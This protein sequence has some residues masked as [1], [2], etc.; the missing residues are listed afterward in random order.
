MKTNWNQLPVFVIAIGVAILMATYSGPHSELVFVIGFAVIFGAI[1]F[2]GIRNSL[3]K[4]RL[5]KQGVPGTARLVSSETTGTYSGHSPEMRLLL[6]V[7]GEAGQTWQ[8]TVTQVFSPAELYALAPGTQ[9]AVLYD[10]TD[11]IKVVLGQPDAANPHQPVGSGS[12]GLA[13][14]SPAAVSV[15]FTPAAAAYL[16]GAAPPPAAP[17]PPNPTLVA[18]Y[19]ELLARQDVIG[20]RLAAAGTLAPATVLN[21][22]PLNATMN[23]GNDP[24]VLLMLQV[25]PATGPAFT[26]ELPAPIA[27]DRV[28]R[29]APGCTVYVRYDPADTRQVALVGS[30]R[31]AG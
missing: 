1:S 5:R 17:A 11:P 15:S 3:L 26:A 2:S 25:T 4:S 31:P 16:A 13:G 8:A 12:A 7:T 27:H 18:A 29:F 28:A 6:D 22:L 14:A 23:S 24:V 21:N 30:E 9:F 10:P 20:Q 19:R